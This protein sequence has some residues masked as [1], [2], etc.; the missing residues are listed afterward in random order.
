MKYVKLGQTGLQV[1]AIVAG[2][3]RLNRLDEMAAAKHIENAVAHGVNFFDHADIYG[4]GVCEEI[5]GKAL[6]QTGIKR[7]EL[8]VQSKCGIVSGVMYDLSKEH[9]INSVDA[10]LKRLNMEYLDALLLH[11]PD[12]LVE[13]EEV[14]EAFDELEASGKVRYFGISNMKPM[15]IELLKKC[16]KQPLIIDQ[17]QVSAAHSSMISNGMEVNMLTAGAVDR[18]G[19]ILDYCRVNDITIQAWS[20]F[21]YGMI[22][23]VFMQNEAFAG[24]TRK[25]EE[26]GEKY[27]VSATTMAV[28]WLLR[29]PAN[30]Q[31]LAGT[32]NED[33]FDE[34]CKACD[35][36]LERRDWY[37]I[38]MAAGNILP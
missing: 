15:Q 11:R 9:I 13:P 21:Q 5:F 30:M 16:V 33:R 25:L 4:R 17:L 26:I 29:H 24:L 12:A 19:S 18:D 36:Q 10:S 7:E 31:V 32:M 27:G 23:G 20:P 2:C 6:A 37:Q 14:A 1:P 3:M 8:F 35:I 38:F 28:A 22:E 34:I